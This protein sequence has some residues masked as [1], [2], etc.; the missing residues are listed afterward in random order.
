MNGLSV[1]LRNVIDYAGKSGFVRLY[2]F[3]KP[4]A[5][6]VHEGGRWSRAWHYDVLT[7]FEIAVG[8]GKLKL[9]AKRTDLMTFLSHTETY[10]FT[11]WHDLLKKLEE[12]I[13]RERV[14]KLEIEKTVIEPLWVRS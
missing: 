10:E 9:V 11:S 14:E 1:A 8:G 7:L 3:A 13:E 6:W 2:G 4:H 5:V 12:L